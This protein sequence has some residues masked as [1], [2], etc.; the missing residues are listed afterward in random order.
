M[1][2]LAMKMGQ[3]L[4]YIDHSV[5][6][7]ARHLLA[8]LQTQS[9]PTPMAR[10][11]EVLEAELG[12]ARFADFDETPIAVASIGQ[13]HRARLPGGEEV[14]VKVQ[15][16]E[17]E[18]AIRADLDNI[19][20]VGRFKALALPNTDAAGMV[21]EIR[22]RLDEECD[23]RR[24][25]RLQ[26]RFRELLAGH[27]TLRVP[28]VF[29]EWSSKRVLTTELARGRSFAAMLAA[30]PPQAERDRIGDA[31][32]DFY[33]ATLYRHRLFNADPHP[34]NY[35]FAD[36]GSVV[37]LDYGCVLEMEPAF[38]G[39]LVALLRAVVDDDGD[40]MHVAMLALGVV[41]PGVRYDRDDA[42]R[43]LR[44][45]YAPILREGPAR[46]TADYTSQTMRQFLTNKNLMKLTMPGEMLFLNRVNFGLLSIMV[47][48]GCAIDWRA[49]T[50]AALEAA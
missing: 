48:L 17:I 41:R 8:L 5:P 43:L 21:A 49:R 25:A 45:L 3:M 33:V 18:A 50:L 13:V 36:D 26:Q 27:P 7:E 29:A 30:N 31:L 42:R 6:P 4:S 23:Y 40:A 47:D 32:F 38:V 34:G 10:V 44:Y 12:G 2:G 24:E 28:R 22:R 16:P 39:K 1:K 9:P 14:A 37:M 11:R 19:G 46:I 15:H 20:L 35:L